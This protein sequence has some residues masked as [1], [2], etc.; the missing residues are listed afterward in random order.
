MRALILIG[1]ILIIE[2]SV[3]CQ[4]ID[5]QK[6]DGGINVEII[7]IL[8]V[9]RILDLNFQAI[10]KIGHIK[11]TVDGDI[12]SVVVHNIVGQQISNKALATIWGRLQNACKEITPKRINSL[13]MEELRALGISSKKGEY[14]K[15]FCMNL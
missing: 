14:I 2:V 6:P 7:P 1:V 8:T 13:S 15:D 12:F 3:T 4:F 9:G 5:K 11:R 10:D